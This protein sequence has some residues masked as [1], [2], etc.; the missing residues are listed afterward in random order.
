MLVKELMTEA[1]V[2]VE[3]EEPVSAAARIMRERNIGALPVCDAEGKPV[4]MVT[5]RDIVTRC[6][7]SGASAESVRVGDVMTRG[8]VTAETNVPLGEA[9]ERMERE[10]IRRLPVT[11]GGRL[12]GILSVADI[13]R[14]GRHAAETAEAL[15]KI[16]SNVC[17]K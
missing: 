16:T 8:A 5:D 13:A 1:P 2:S 14:T 15:S 6:V 3:A 17:R 12:V 10:Q 4:G 11:E 9:L 7:A